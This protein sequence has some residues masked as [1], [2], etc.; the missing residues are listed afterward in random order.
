M[1]FNSTAERNIGYHVGY[2]APLVLS[3]CQ[4]VIN[5]YV[6][7]YTVFLILLFKIWKY[8]SVSFIPVIIALA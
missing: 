7:V 8:L 3:F 5:T 2:T 1:K 4:F 6:T